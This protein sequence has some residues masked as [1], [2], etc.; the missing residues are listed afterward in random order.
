[1]RKQK[2]KVTKINKF[3]LFTLMATGITIGMLIMKVAINGIA[4]ISTTGLLG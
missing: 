3:D 4:W 2:N 1:M